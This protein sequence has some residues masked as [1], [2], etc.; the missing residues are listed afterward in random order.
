MIRCIII[1]DQAPAQRI[2]QKYIKQ[3]GMLQLQE[4]FTDPIQALDYLKSHTVD[5]IFLDIHLPKLSGMDFLKVLDNSPM[6]IL[7]TAYHQYAVQSYEFD[8]LDYLL[9]PI[10]YP[11][12]LKAMEKMNQ[13]TTQ[14]HELTQ[15][16]G[17]ILVKIGYDYVSISIDDILYIQTDG[18][19]THL[20]C[21]EKKYLVAL[22]LKYWLEQ[23]PQHLFCQ[24]HRSYLV[25]TRK[26]EKLSTLSLTIN[27]QA[28]PIGRKYK[29]MIKER[30]KNTEL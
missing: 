1:E 25:A 22:P 26:I 2:L 9:K 13:H 16:L 4:T 19:Y 21:T 11:R 5:L 8:V 14:R 12:F 28:I 3:Y 18:D 6:V 30:M 27:N 17:S 24:V 23:L 29:Q 10:S 7:T 20:Y 15:T